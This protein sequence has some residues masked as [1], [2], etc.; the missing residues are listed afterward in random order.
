MIYDPKSIA[1][2]FIETAAR[3]GKPLTP[4]QVI[5]LVYIAHG[6]HLGLTDEPLINEPPEAWKYGPVIPSV[7]HALKDYGNE[8]IPTPITS[9]DLVSRDPIKFSSRTVPPP[10]DQN[11]VRFLQSVWKAYGHL[12]GIQLSTLTHQPNTP[13]FITW[14]KEGAKYSK[15]VDIPEGLIKDHYKELRRKNAARAAQPAQ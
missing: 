1:N 10:D 5:K 15:G 6:W 12:G 4:L 14:E 8:P 9:Y 13:W 7:Y 2:F 11:T 3:E